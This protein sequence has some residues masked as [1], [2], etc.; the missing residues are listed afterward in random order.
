MRFDTYIAYSQRSDSATAR[1][2][3]RGLENL[4]RPWNRRRALHVF[5]DDSVLSLTPELWSSISNAL[6]ESDWLIVLASPESAASVWVNREISYWLETKPASHILLILTGGDLV[7]D[8]DLGDF[9]KDESS[10]LPHS[11]FGAF[12]EEPRYLDLRWTKLVDERELDLKHPR[13]REAVAE[14]AAPIHEVSR[15]DIEGEAVRVERRTMRLRNYAVAALSTLTLLSILLAVGLL[16]QTRRDGDF[17]DFVEATPTTSPTQQI[18]TYAG[19]ALSVGVALL[20]ALNWRGFGRALVVSTAWLTGAGIGSAWKQAISVVVLVV[21]GVSAALVILFLTV[22]RPV[23]L[24]LL[25][26]SATSF[27]LGLAA[28]VRSRSA[29]RGSKLVGAESAKTAVIRGFVDRFT[30]ISS[31]Q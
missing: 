8:L 4:A 1:A 18:F 23:W 7:W 15:A 2:L 31:A 13:F 3:E 20:F 26:I 30:E 27:G 14:V 29:T 19:T 12:N 9:S 24:G 5:R 16:Q 17:P 11:L 10:A 28:I 21:P 22:S 25:S 6:L